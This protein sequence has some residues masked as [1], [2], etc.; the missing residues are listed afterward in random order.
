MNIVK[1]EILWTRACNLNCPYCG[2]MRRGKEAYSPKQFPLWLKGLKNLK[3]LG[4]GFLAIY[5]AEPL[6]DM[7]FLGEFIYEATNLNI[8]HTLITN[9]SLPDTRARISELISFGLN[10]LTVSFDGNPEQITSRDVVTKTTNALET[11]KWFQLIKP[12][13]RD[14]AVVFTATRKNLSQIIEWIPI[15]SDMG[16]YTFFDLIHDD[17]GLPGTKC[18][19]YDGME[20]LLFRPKDA[21]MLR[22]FGRKLWELKCLDKYLIH[23][24]KPFID[25]LMNDPGLYIHRLWNCAREKTFPAWVTIDYDGLVRVCDDFYIDRGKDWYVWEL[26]REVFEGEFTKHWQEVTR[27]FCP[28]CFWNTHFDAHRILEG[29]ITLDH[30][31]NKQPDKP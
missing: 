2:I 26:T 17:I 14:V 4:C 20:E 5:G 6:M 16:I 27:D 3:K 30:Y 8:L 9:C 11:I 28:G 21:N 1:A 13:Y 22:D 12:D 18:R 19:H 31:V 23:Q 29:E 15:L 25:M 24:S 10:S 7:K